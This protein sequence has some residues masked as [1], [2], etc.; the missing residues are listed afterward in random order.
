ME[1]H[2]PHHNPTMRLGFA[3]LALAAAACPAAAFTIPQSTSS[4]QR[5]TAATNIF[6]PSTVPSIASTALRMSTAVG[7]DPQVA[8]DD[9]LKAAGSGV[10]LF[11][12]SGW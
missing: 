6:A 5:A 12:K 8:I 10:T 1:K 2:T 9:A 3:V 7:A 11:G 4:V